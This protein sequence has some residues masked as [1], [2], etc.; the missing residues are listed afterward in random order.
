MNFNLTLI[1]QSIAMIVFVWFCMKYIWPPMIAALEE[2]KQKVADG[3]A[4]GERG[5]H[6]LELA[7]SRA[8]EL[9]KEARAQAAQIREQAN[10]QAVHIKDQAKVDAVAERERQLT[11]AQ[12]EI[13][14]EASRTKEALRAQ[15][16]ALAVAGAEQLLKREVNADAHQDLLD[17]LAAEI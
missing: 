1:G 5:Q 6:E 9:L 17:K 12:A 15:V 8:T 13:E 10:Q 11:A 14:Q 16:A 2:R 7:Q 4:A 3:I